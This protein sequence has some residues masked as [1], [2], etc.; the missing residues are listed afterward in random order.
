M[1]KRIVVFALLAALL[2]GVLAACEG[3]KDYLTEEDAVKIAVEDM[4]I[5]TEDAT[6]IHVHVGT[7]DNLPCFNVYITCKNV[8]KTYVISSIS[9]EILSIQDGGEHSH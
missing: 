7:H 9:G 8:S 4:G 1:F 5:K 3:K 6:S 2:C